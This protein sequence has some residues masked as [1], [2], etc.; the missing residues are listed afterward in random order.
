MKN[1]KKLE[2]KKLSRND[3]KEIK[4]SVKA[5]WV[6]DGCPWPLCPNQFGRCSTF[7]TCEAYV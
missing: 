1:F 2:G 7:G 3:L 4:G 5:P 6:E